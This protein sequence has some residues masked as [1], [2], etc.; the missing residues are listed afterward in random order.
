VAAGV[1]PDFSVA[2]ERAQYAELLQTGD[3]NHYI[4]RE[5][6]AQYTNAC[7]HGQDDFRSLQSLPQEDKLMTPD[8]SLMGSQRIN[9]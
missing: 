7:S 5:S 1:F 2:K 4:Y 9:P 3:R 8:F 6:F